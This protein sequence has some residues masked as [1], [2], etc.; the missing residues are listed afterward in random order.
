MKEQS[1][2]LNQVNLRSAQLEARVFGCLKHSQEASL[3]EMTFEHW[4]HLFSLPGNSP[5]R[6]CITFLFRTRRGLLCSSILNAFGSTYGNLWRTEGQSIEWTSHDTY[7][8]FM[9]LCWAGM[10]KG[11]VERAAFV[12]PLHIEAYCNAV[13]CTPRVSQVCLY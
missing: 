13:V 1:V 2:F 5:I 3:R 12:V 7:N 4:S 10:T 9:R 8:G 6:Q 11:S